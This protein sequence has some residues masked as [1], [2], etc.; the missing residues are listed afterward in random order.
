VLRNSGQLVEA[1][2]QLY[3]SLQIAE[4]ADDTRGVAYEAVNNGFC[5][6]MGD[7]AL[8]TVAQLLRDGCRTS[9][10]VGRYGDEEFVL[11]RV[12]TPAAAAVALCDKMRRRIA[13]HD[14][15]L[16]HPGLS[17]VTVSIGVA[18]LGPDEAA[19]ALLARVDRQYY[20]AKG[21]GPNR[22]CG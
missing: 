19:A 5:H 17:G 4:A 22:V 21:E 11:V 2:E 13:D 6:A 20:R 9:D 12:E 18:G 1:L 10:V 15:S 14:W 16:L 8:R 7:E 3:R